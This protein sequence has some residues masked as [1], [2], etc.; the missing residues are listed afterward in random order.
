VRRAFLHD[1]AACAEAGR[2]KQARIACL[3]FKALLGLLAGEFGFS[4][5]I[6]RNGSGRIDH[7]SSP[8][9]VR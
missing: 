5:R 4:V 7:D 2:E 8:W 1:V 6:H 9:I 3:E